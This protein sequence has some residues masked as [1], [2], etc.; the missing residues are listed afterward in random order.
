MDE[1]LEVAEDLRRSVSFSA[2]GDVIVVTFIEVEIDPRSTLAR[3]PALAL[4]DRHRG[5]VSGDDVRSCDLLADLLPD[6]L[7]ELGAAR[8]RPLQHAAAE[9]ESFRSILLLQPVIRQV[10]QEAL[11]HHV[12]QKS[13]TE[14]T[15]VDHAIGSRSGPDT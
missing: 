1:T 12:R 8:H 3:L 11:G 14:E 6:R 13:L 9:V 10:V 2:V 4:R 15:L 5:V 7:Q